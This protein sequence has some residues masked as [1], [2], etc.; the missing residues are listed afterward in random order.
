MPGIP[1]S[2]AK[3]AP[4][5][6]EITNLNDDNPDKEIPAPPSFK[7]PVKSPT[8]NPTSPNTIALVPVAI[9]RAP[10]TN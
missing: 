7:S 5:L 6:E 10:L 2:E 9:R 4:L 1:S 3:A 8:V